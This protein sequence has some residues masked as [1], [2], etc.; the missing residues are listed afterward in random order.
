M[1]CIT[2]QNLSLSII[3]SSCQNTLLQPNFHKR[4][5]EKDF[6][7]YSFYGYDEIKELINSKYEFYG[8]KVFNILAKLSF[9]KFAQEFKYN[10][11]I[12]AIPID[13]HT[14]HQFS[15]TAILAKVLKSDVIKPIYGTLKAKNII[16]YAGR[17]LEFRKS[18][19]RKFI[20][21]GKKNL[22]VILIDDLIT[23]GSTITEAKN[24]V[25]QY[26]CNVLF[27]LVLADARVEI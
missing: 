4:E 17:D 20:Y 24:K 1:R 16:K 11:N 26:G 14:R 21:S 25:E 3:C 7:A 9:E 27:G 23:T 5:L 2:C 22:D 19:P 12:S 10:G 6:Y 8:D 13:D 18:N 15:Q